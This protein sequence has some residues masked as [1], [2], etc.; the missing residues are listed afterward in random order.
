MGSRSFTTK[1]A[2]GSLAWPQFPLDAEFM[3]CFYGKD[4][5]LSGSGGY[6]TSQALHLP[7]RAGRVERVEFQG[8]VHS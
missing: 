7:S 4:P 6:E 5:A 8:Q 2:M 3:E 1:G